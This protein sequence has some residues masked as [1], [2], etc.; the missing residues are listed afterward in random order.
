MQ[1]QCWSRKMKAVFGLVGICCKY[2]TTVFKK[3]SSW[4]MNFPRRSQKMVVESYVSITVCENDRW[5]FSFHDH[6][7]KSSFAPCF[8]R[9]FHDIFIKRSWK[10]QVFVKTGSH[11]SVLLKFYE[12][13]HRSPNDL[14]PILKESRHP[15]LYNDA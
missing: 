14:K 5:N 3:R 4:K 10:L 6:F 11:I 13:S 8:W 12:T 2:S 9:T 1:L 7:R 15:E